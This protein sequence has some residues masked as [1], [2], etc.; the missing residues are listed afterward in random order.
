MTPKS[1][2]EITMT[3]CKAASWYLL[4]LVVIFIASGCQS[5]EEREA[6]T[7]P[8]RMSVAI[9]SSLY[10]GLVAI[11]DG[12]GFFR[13]SGIEVSIHEFPSGLSAVEA[14]LRGEAQMATAAD[15]V[16]VLK[17]G[18]DPSL[19]IV[20]S[21]GLA[22]TSRI[23]ARKDRNIT[24]PSDLRGKRIGVTPNTIS[25][26]Y[27]HTFLLAHGI[28]PSEVTVVNLPPDGMAGAIADGEVDAISIWDVFVYH[29]KKRLG[30]N[31]V[32]WEAQNTQDFHWILMAREGVI[33]SPEPVKRFL[34]ALVNAQAFLLSHEDEAKG[35]IMQR[36]DFEPGFMRQNWEGTRLDVSLSQSLIRALD[37]AA[38]WKMRRDGR[39]A[40]PPNFLNYIHTGVL[41]EV[42]PRSVTIFR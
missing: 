20:A 23:V 24:E 39:F 1:S 10:S 13:E 6:K 16:F 5:R 34:K 14:M 41:D 26:Y 33:Q 21:I 37:N 36:W 15:L 38:N 7:A 42:D 25:E 27:L 40:E 12:K 2:S 30:E 17:S 32:S 11:A 35:I 28:P 9:G 31:A 4:L 29:A 22:N 3:L 19:R 8:L 18:E